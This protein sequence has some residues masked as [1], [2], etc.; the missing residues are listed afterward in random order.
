MKYRKLRIAWSVGWGVA[1]LL[2]ITLWI[3]SRSRYSGIEGHIGKQTFSVVSSLG[4]INIYLF[5]AAAVPTLP[6]RFT[7][8]TVSLEEVVMPEHRGFDIYRNIA[9]VGVFVSYW[10]L[11]LLAGMIAAAAWVPRRF[12]LRTLL[13]GMTV[14]AVTLGLIFALSR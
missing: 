7:D 5:T 3:I 14:V 6:W 10:V 2:L 13:I 1:C 4:Q 8:S 11:V 9:A 12:S